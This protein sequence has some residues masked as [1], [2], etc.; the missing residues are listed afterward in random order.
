MSVLGVDVSRSSPILYFLAI[1]LTGKGTSDVA[2][3][4]FSEELF[5][6]II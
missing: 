1:E 3:L 5:P 2:V 4:V 6:L